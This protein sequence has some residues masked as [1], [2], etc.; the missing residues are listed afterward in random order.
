MAKAQKADPA[1]GIGHNEAPLVAPAQAVSE[2]LLRDYVGLAES[3]TAIL[4][5]ARDLPLKVSD[6][7]ELG[8]FS[9]I[10]KSMR[11][12]IAKAEAFRV[13]EKE[14]YLRGG[15]A[16]DGFFQNLSERLNKGMKIVTA[17]VNDYQQAILAAERRKREEEAA[18]ARRIAEEARLAAER[19]RKPAIAEAKEVQ[20]TI[21]ERRADVAEEAAEATPAA[22]TRTRF[23]DGVLVTMKKVKYV[24]IVDADKIPLDRLRPYLKPSEIE[25]AVKRWAAATEYGSVMSGVEVGERD[26]TV[27]R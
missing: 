11:D 3:T 6:N 20:A 18:E 25:A 10:A 21:A 2:S 24:T 22:M 14:P 19:A 17:R 16:V 26:D 12:T 8:Q 7:T 4:A 27:I 23:D 9:A 15:Q 5:Q 1:P 13:K